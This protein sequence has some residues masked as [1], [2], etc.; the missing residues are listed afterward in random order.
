M[1]LDRFDRTVAEIYES[2]LDPRHWDLALTGL[3]NRSAP[4]RWDVAFLMWETIAPPGGRFVGAVGVNDFARAGY[5]QAFAGRNPWSV[6]SHGLP[7]GSLVHSDELMPR[8]EFH[9]CEL[10]QRFL[11]NWGM[12][13]AL[14]GGVDRAG[15]ERL[16]LVIP[17]PDSGAL[18]DLRAAVRRYLPH[19]QRAS[20]ISR[21]LG[22]ANLRAVN[23]ENA[24]NASP[25]ASLILGSD[26]ALQFANH[27][28]E[29]MLANGYGDLREGRLRL[30]DPAAQAKLSAL[31]SGADPVPSIAL[32]LETES[33]QPLRLLAMRIDPP[34]AD[35]LSGKIEGGSVLV[36]ASQFEG[37]VRAELLDRY[38]EWFGLTPAEARLAA[39][40]AKGETLE[41]FAAS[42]GVTVNAGR[43]LLKG[44]FGKTG[45]SKQAQLVALLRDAPDGMIGSA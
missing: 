3:I 39:M 23:A 45:V 17:G 26:L 35:T 10:Y 11:S 32:V 40:L 42:R 13:V 24:L 19:I 44:I 27:S 25:N 28:G 18:D 9:A 30:R 21:K 7:V 16:G 33:H 6:R 38:T 31:A 29:A 34:V 41:Q 43:F 8:A 15:A 37:G 4:P 5:L 2:A 14:I 1:T 36:V 12:D 20:R 22:E